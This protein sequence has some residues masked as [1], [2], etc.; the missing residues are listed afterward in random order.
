MLLIMVGSG[1]NGRARKGK[2][3]LKVNGVGVRTF[4]LFTCTYDLVSFLG[5]LNKTSLDVRTYVPIF[6]LPIFLMIFGMWVDVDEG[7][8]TV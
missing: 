5:H 3:D 1:V 2:G 7:C 6:F 8:T 4:P